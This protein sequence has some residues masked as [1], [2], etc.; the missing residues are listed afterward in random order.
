ML[1]AAN[2]LLR[3][4]NRYFAIERRITT[5]RWAIP[6]VVANG[7]RLLTGAVP[8]GWSRPVVGRAGPLYLADAT[9]E[10]SEGLL[11]LF[12]GVF[13]GKESR[14]AQF[15]SISV[16]PDFRESARARVILTS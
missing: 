10:L 15:R 14:I 5:Y 12:F 8:H 9:P 4:P 16:V 1:P 11:N 3:V 13:D 6:T 7:A 2:A